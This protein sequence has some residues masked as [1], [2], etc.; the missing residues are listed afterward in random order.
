MSQGARLTVLL[1]PDAWPRQGD[2]LPLPQHPASTLILHELLEKA[3]GTEG[4]VH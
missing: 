3:D 1:E 4:K 2:L